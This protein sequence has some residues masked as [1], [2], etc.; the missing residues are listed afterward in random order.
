MNWEKKTVTIVTKAYPEQSKRHGSVACT[1]GI[2]NDGKWIRLYPIDMR[3]FVGNN[4]ISKL[5]S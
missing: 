4:K 3:Y 5:I 1:A 2:T